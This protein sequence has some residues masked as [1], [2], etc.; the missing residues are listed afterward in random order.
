MRTRF[1]KLTDFFYPFYSKINDDNIFAIAGQSAF[2]LVLSIFPLSMFCVSVLQNLHIPIETLEKAFRVVLNETAT[3][4]ASNFLGNFYQNATGISFITIIMTL[5]SAAQ[6]I[7]AITNGLNRIHGTHEN[8]NWFFLRLRAMVY[9]VVFVAILAATIAVLV[10]G[11]TLHSVI[12]PHLK[13]LPDSIHVLFNLR[14]LIVFAYLVIL[15]MFIYRNIPNLKRDRRRE[16]GFRSQ[17]PGAFFCASA[18]FVLS[19]G[20]SIYVSDFNGFSI[21]GGL[22]RLA[23]I[24]IWLYF[25]IVCLMTGAEFNYVYHKQIKEFSLR[26]VFRRKTK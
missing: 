1:K 8:R 9:T 2:F 11:S 14:Y 3:E 10:L 24:M 12:S 17:F 7:H 5:W 23:V 26:R 13:N 22:T 18:W 19:L 4:Y 25:C 16:Y 21:Y 15:F 20:I 6:G